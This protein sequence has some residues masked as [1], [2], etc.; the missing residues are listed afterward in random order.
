MAQKF[1]WLFFMRY[2]PT[3]IY[4]YKTSARYFTS[5]SLCIGRSDY[6]ILGS[7]DHKDWHRYS[8]QIL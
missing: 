3:I 6:F 5:E 4:F 7:S 2:M 8:A 1:H